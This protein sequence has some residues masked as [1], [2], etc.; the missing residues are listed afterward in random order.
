MT[1]PPSLNRRRGTSRYEGEIDISKSMRYA[2]VA[3]IAI[4]VMGI[5]YS[6]HNG[7]TKPELTQYTKSNNYQDVVSVDD[8]FY[9]NKQK[10]AN[11]NIDEHMSNPEQA[12]EVVNAFVH[13]NCDL[14][15]VEWF[16]TGQFAWQQ[17]GPYF[18]LIGA[19]KAGTSALSSW[20][21]NHPWTS[22]ARTKELLY[23]LPTHF[24]H[25]SKDG[26]VLVREARAE[27]YNVESGDYNA[28]QLSS[29]D[30]WV[31]FDATPGYLFKTSTSISAILCTCP[32]VKLL[33]TLREPAA[34]VLS[35]Y[36]FQMDPN[37]GRFT[38]MPFEDWI[39]HDF[40][41][42]RLAGVIQ[43][44]IPNEEFYGSD[45]EKRAWDKYLG[46]LVGDEPAAIGRSLYV[47]QI[48]A[49]YKAL[50]DIGRD[51]E[52]EFMVVRNEE[53]HQKP[54][55]LC[56]T[57]FWWLE[58]PPNHSSTYSEVLTT[59]YTLAKMKNETKA[60]LKE[61]FKPYNKRLYKLLGEDW[62]D[63]WDDGMVQKVPE[64]QLY[65]EV[66][67]DD[68][69][70][71]EEEMLKGIQGNNKAVPNETL[72]KEGT[73]NFAPTYEHP[74]YNK[75][76]GQK[77]TEKWCD[78]TGEEW[79]PTADQDQWKFRAP[80]FMLPGAKKSGTTSLASYISQHPLVEGARTKELQFFM[81]KNFRM[82]YVD[83]NRK[84]L[85][86]KARETMYKMEYHSQILISNRSKISFDATPGYL[87]FSSMLPHRILCVCPWIK[88]VLILRNPIDR[89]Y[90][91]HAYV[92]KITGMKMDFENWIQ[93]DLEAL[94]QSGFLDAKNE[95]EE[96]TAWPRYLKLASEGPIGRSIYDVQIRHW[97]KAFEESGRDPTTQI[98]IVRS[99]DMHDSKAGVYRKVLDFLGL[100][101]APLNDE[102]E[103]V[104]SEYQHAMKNETREMLRKFFEPYN[105]R[106]Y[107]RLGGDWEG[108]WDKGV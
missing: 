83:E 40:I 14:T 37:K 71:T 61:F 41:Q 95:E 85:V 2:F 94:N 51:P 4:M 21:R 90:S 84:T 62:T 16:P 59:T 76:E 63:E 38:T 80:Y 108:Y 28:L 96:D 52:T 79:Y 77:F 53:M 20:L 74:V 68:E 66:V 27:M 35:H 106:L 55:E 104:V 23:F 3:A 60:M 25:R 57:I 8:D 69:A 58:M 103:K 89:A 9:L 26:K 24:K 42:L 18:L 12:V 15:G 98:H 44:E 1:H 87:F 73:V 50:V 30:T 81:N 6:S 82:E 17:R 34:R 49:W 45:R 93:N 11:A 64:H 88:L 13:E 97:R 5:S 102:T 72:S 46:M 65:N 43:N 101:V 48:E 105:K 70:T 75:K 56:N 54:D 47:I 29:S 33:V 99:E 32:W 36:N 78:L 7:T 107:E 19:K 22:I 67:D 100:P 31:S 91:N 10:A 39:E 92:Q 86:K